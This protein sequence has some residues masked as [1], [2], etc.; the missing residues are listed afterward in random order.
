[1]SKK[2][3]LIGIN[4]YK[5]PKVR[6]NG[7]VDDIVNMRNML[8][9]AYGYSYSNT[10]L[11]RD[12]ATDVNNLPTRKN[13]INALNTLVAN[14]ASCTEVWFHY[15][16]HGAKVKT[17]NTNIDSV[18]V[19]CDYLTAGLILDNDLYDIF[20][21]VKCRCIL[22]F[23]SCNS[24]N[25]VELP[26]SFQYILPKQVIKTKINNNILAN[27]EIYMFSACK[28]TQQSVDIYSADLQDF[29][30]AFTNA[31][32]ICLREAKHE[33]QLL[34]LYNDV[35]NYLYTNK[36]SQIPIFSSTLNNPNYSLVRTGSNLNSPTID[37]TTITQI[38][39]NTDYNSMTIIS[40]NFIPFTSSSI[41]L[42]MPLISSSVSMTMPFGSSSVSLSKMN[43]N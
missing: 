39:T 1:M 20:K 17:S 11:L 30:G 24:G 38:K 29:V 4:Y 42:S 27:C 14:S 41:S 6:L 5:I 7:C 2:A 25:M 3:L 37:T 35:C 34:K 43:L 16:G 19:P 13:I 8:I 18:I 40:K 10:T 23:D 12:D 33:V 22:L 32:L 26:W 15:S 21:N 31:F 36:F 28:D 9:D